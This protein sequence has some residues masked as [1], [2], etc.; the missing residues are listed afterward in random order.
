[1]LRYLLVNKENFLC[2]TSSLTEKKNTI[3][4]SI[5]PFQYVK[6]SGDKQF[7]SIVPLNISSLIGFQ[8]Y[9]HF[10]YFIFNS[11]LQIHLQQGNEKQNW[12]KNWVV[13]EIHN[14]SFSDHWSTVMIEGS[15]NCEDKVG[16]VWIS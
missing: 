5:Q 2:F 13:Q 7:L 8:A 1:M 11:H 6:Q 15:I 4:S 14:F 3:S 16:R 10:I 9:T 12:S